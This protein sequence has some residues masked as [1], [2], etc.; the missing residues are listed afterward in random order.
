MNFFILFCIFS[1]AVTII[2]GQRNK[3]DNRRVKNYR[4]R[5]VEVGVYLD[6]YV[7]NTMKQQVGG[8]NSCVQRKTYKMIKALF[9]DTEVLFKDSSIS[10]YGGFDLKVNGI[11]IIKNDYDREFSP[12]HQT[13]NQGRQLDV[14][15]KYARS[16]NNPDDKKRNSYDIS[17]LLTGNNRRGS[18]PS[19]LSHID[20]VCHLFGAGV[21]TLKLRNG[22]HDGAHILLAHE[23]GHL[24]GVKDHDGTK[25][26]RE[27]RGKTIMKPTVEPDFTKWS[28]C[29]RKQ[30]DYAYDRRARNRHTNGNCFYV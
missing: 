7:W 12:I 29:S 21:M 2:Q 17:F 18:V 25:S 27:C 5:T 28:A 10:R 8:S 13:T 26:A 20:R 9:K 16:R 11:K 23:L 6:K 4:R 19:G 22:K 24:M 3:V 1:Q 15:E 30:I 14:F